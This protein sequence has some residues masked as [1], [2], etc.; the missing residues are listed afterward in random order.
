M[1]ESSAVETWT[2]VIVPLTD[3]L[4]SADNNTAMAVVERRLGSLL[5]GKSEIHIRLHL[6]FGIWV[7]CV[8]VAY[9]E[10]HLNLKDFV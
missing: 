6:E 8:E 3:D 2:V 5:E 4:S 1:F 10:I 9:F 7:C